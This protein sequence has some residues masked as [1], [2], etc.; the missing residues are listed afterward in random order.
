MYVC[1]LVR[2]FL[3]LCTCGMTVLFDQL[4]KAGMYVCMYVCMYV[5]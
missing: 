3:L 4:R 1:V 2:V 5:F